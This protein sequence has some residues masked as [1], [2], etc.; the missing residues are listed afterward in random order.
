VVPEA[1]LLLDGYQALQEKDYA[2]AE[3]LLD[4]AHQLTP[5]DN[6]VLLNLAVV[7]QATGR[8]DRAVVL[9]QKI[10]DGDSSAR[11]EPHVAEDLST[12][13]HAAGPSV[14]DI[15]RYNLSL[16][17]PTGDH[18]LREGY[19]ALQ[20]KDYGQAE[21]LMD[22]ARAR[23]PDN[24]FVLLNLAV[25]YQLTGRTV[26]AA[27]LFGQLIAGNTKSSS[28]PRVVALAR[29]NLALIELAAC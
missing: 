21:A 2:T 25:V 12:T 23:A 4:Q 27:Q 11:P 9:Y 20:S 24:E 28:Q 17:D 15:A 1:N 13:V 22:Q 26:Q 5:G 10:I 16:I 8:D 29:R 3:T 19:E 6:Y 14:A 18:A 7:Y